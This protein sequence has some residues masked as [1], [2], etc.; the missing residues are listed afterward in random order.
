MTTVRQRR[1]RMERGQ[2]TMKHPHHRQRRHR[3]VFLITNTITRTTIDPETG[4]PIAEISHEA[5]VENDEATGKH[6]LAMKK[7]GDDRFA[8]HRVFRMQIDD[9]G[10]A[11]VTTEVRS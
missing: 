2:L 5:H 7:A 9:R 8:N 4:D 10:K 11:T 3:I 6:V 1:E